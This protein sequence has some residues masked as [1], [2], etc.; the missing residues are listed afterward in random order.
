LGRFPFLPV[1][2]T[3]PHIRSLLTAEEAASSAL[4]VDR[5]SRSSLLAVRRFLRF[6]YPRFKE[7]VMAS[8]QKARVVVQPNGHINVFTSAETLYSL[9]AIQ[10]LLSGILGRTGCPTCCS[11]RQVFFQQ[12]E[13]EFVVE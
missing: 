7:I 4:V 11:G 8:Q 3:I 1:S 13:A 5:R 2:E 12:E 6:A 10:N 9:S